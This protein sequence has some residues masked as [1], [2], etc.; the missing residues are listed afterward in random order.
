M[1]TGKI[2]NWNGRTGWIANDK[3]GKDV[4]LHFNSVPKM[5]IDDIEQGVAVEFDI[6]DGGVY[7]AP[8]RLDAHNFRLLQ[9][10]PDKTQD[11]FF[12]NPYTF[13][14]T[15]PRPSNGFAGDFDP[16]KCGLDHASLKDDLWTGH[17]PIKLTTI[18][19]LV[20]L[21]AGGEDPA[22]DTHQTYDVLDYI[23]ESSLRGML[24]STYEV[25]TN[26][27]YGCFSNEEPLEYR[28]VVGKRERKKYDKSPL[29]LLDLSLHPASSMS[30]LSP[31]DRL[32]GWAPSP[33]SINY[34]LDRSVKSPVKQHAKRVKDL[35]NSQQEPED[36]TTR[37]Y[38]YQSLQYLEEHDLSEFRKLMKEQVVEEIY[39]EYQKRNEGGYKSRLRVVCEDGSRPE[40]IQ[41]FEEGQHLS[42]AILSQPKPSYA[43]F[44][45]AKNPDG[46]PQEDKISKTAAGYSGDKGLRGR[47]QYWHHQ[48]LLTDYWKLPVEEQG[49]SPNENRLNQEYRRLDE[50]DKPKKDHQNRSIRGWIKTDTGFKVSLYVQNLQS[51]E[52]GALLWLLSLPDK[53]YFRLGYGKPLGFGSVT[54]KIDEA[55][56]LDERLPLGTGQHWKEY[57]GDLNALST[58]TELNKNQREEYIKKFMTKMEKAYP[59]AQCFD[60]LPFISRFLQVLRGPGK[61]A[62]IHYPR[63]EERPDPEGKNFNKWFDDNEKG[64]KLPLPKAGEGVPYDP[65]T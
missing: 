20:L 9:P 1:A 15:P 59:K 12:H 40:I 5:D 10:S 45:V 58:P 65:Q 4:F 60:N 38:V 57:Y 27:R 26:S 11:N 24:R 34:C 51:V 47:K 17:I 55:R 54:I 39:K 13:V 19:P 30:A 49:Q 56:C 36:A 41:R 18:T 29:E 46:D 14:P 43:R 22:S 37:A 63:T 3:G 42:L 6:Q 64:Q 16:L 48:G 62:L 25:V 35:I 50:D 21:D 33:V 52:V 7:K 61:D 31:A 53:C 28:E 8:G 44:Y 32:F 23:P 2:K